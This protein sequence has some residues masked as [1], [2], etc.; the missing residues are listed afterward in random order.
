MLPNS[1]RFYRI[2]IPSLPNSVTSYRISVRFYRK[3]A[4]VSTEYNF[5]TCELLFGNILPNSVRSYRTFGKKLPNRVI[6][7][8]WNKYSVNFTERFR[9]IYQIFGNIVPNLVNIYRIFGN[10]LPNRIIFVE[11]YQYLVDAIW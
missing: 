7:V 4:E 10:I 3:K 11:S 8:P 6:I 5:A 2:S 1:V 9:S